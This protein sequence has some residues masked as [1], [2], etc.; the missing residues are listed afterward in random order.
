MDGKLPDAYSKLSLILAEANISVLELH[1]RLEAMG[2]PVNVK[3]LY[4]LVESSPLQKIDLRIAAAV[5]QLFKLALGDLIS[6]EKPRARWRPL[7]PKMQARLDLLMEKNNEGKLTPGEHEEFMN[8]SAEA[9]RLS[10]ENARVLLA[11]RQ[12][13]KRSVGAAIRAS[14]R[15]SRKPVRT[16]RTAMVS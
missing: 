14:A 5:C 10:M 12:R 11:E 6:F 3:S 15:S 16:S 1:R 9:H 13:A 7:A 4:R 2:A 8:L